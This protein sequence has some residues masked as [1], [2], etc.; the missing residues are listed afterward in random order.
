MR[1]KGIEQKNPKGSKLL[2][3]GLHMPESSSKLVLQ[4]SYPG[5]FLASAG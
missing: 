3:H 1:K 4:T 2:S 5:A